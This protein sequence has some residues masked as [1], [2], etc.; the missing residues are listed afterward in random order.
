MDVSPEGSAQSAAASPT[1]SSAASSASVPARA[2][3]SAASTIR[4]TCSVVVALAVTE[5]D[6]VP[7]PVPC[8]ATT[9][10]EMPC[11]TPLVVSV[12]LAHRRLA[13]VESCTITTQWSDAGGVQGVLDELLRGGEVMI[14]PPL[15]C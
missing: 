15:W 5:P 8:N 12:L 13:L 10:T 7:V 2:A 14:P 9:V 6:A 11:I 1:G 4:S 3:A